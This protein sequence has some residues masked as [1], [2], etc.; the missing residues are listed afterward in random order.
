MWGHRYTGGPGSI[1]RPVLKEG[2]K[3]RKVT[4]PSVVPTYMYN[5]DSFPMYLSG[6]GYLLTAAV[7]PCLH[8][9]AMNLPF[10]HIEVR[11]RDGIEQR[12][13]R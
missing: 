8:R 3:P 5:K 7:I 10:F 9:E 12:A 6:S 13:I 4:L 2:E 1:M 11:L